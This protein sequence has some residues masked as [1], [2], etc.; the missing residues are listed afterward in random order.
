VWYQCNT[1][2]GGLRGAWGRLR[3]ASAAQDVFAAEG[4]I[5]QGG[6]SP[7]AKVVFAEE[8]PGTFT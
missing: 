1:L 8:A 4:I 6:E 5:D 7:R 3:G 2:L